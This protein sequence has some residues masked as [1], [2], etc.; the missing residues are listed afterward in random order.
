MAYTVSFG[1]MSKRENS[2]KQS[3]TEA[4]SASCLLKETTDILNP[5][6]SIQAQIV[7][8]T[9]LPCNYMYV[10]DFGRYYWITGIEFYHGVW[11]VSGETDVLATFKTEIGNTTT[12]IL[13]AA[14][15]H[16]DRIID[17]FYA[18]ENVP[19]G[20]PVWENTEF[21][22]TGTVILTVLG[23]DNDTDSYCY[24]AMYPAT[25]ARLYSVMY[26][27]NFLSGIGTFWQGIFTD[28]FNTIINPG[29]FIS[30]AIWLPI[31]YD[32]IAGTPTNIFIANFQT[33]FVG[34]HITPNTLLCYKSKTLTLPDHPQE[35]TMGV[36][37]RGNRASK[38]SLLLPGYGTIVLDSDK[39][40]AMAVRT[41]SIQYAVDCSGAISYHVNYGGNDVYCSADIGTPC[42]YGDLRPDFSQ[43]VS[44]L[45]MAGASAVAGNIPAI[46]KGVLDAT[47][48][49]KPSVERISSGGSRTLPTVMPYFISNSTFYLLP[50]NAYDNA[51]SGRPLADTRQI[52]TLSGYIVCCDTVSVECSGTRF[53]IEKINNYLSGGFYYE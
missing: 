18:L 13:R 38:D 21:D 19:T 35:A 10:A 44:S 22:T 14:S 46:A 24:Y 16:N 26:N 45:L 47:L 33:S 8:D 2:T 52:S 20:S 9:L 53:E 39:I 48:A 27:S 4:L 34:K 23:N 28:I 15:Q 43:A 41:I 31:K 11:Y 5:T 51:G 30:S 1:V 3:Y 50:A 25:W 17:G 29:D 37:L 49:T 36:W 40:A 42:G 7:G 6:F 32:D 12:Y